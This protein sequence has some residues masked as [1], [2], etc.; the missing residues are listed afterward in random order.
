VRS[1]DKYM[2][3]KGSV[4]LPRQ[5]QFGLRLWQLIADVITYRG[6]V[7]GINRF[8][9]SKIRDRAT[10]PSHFLLIRAAICDSLPKIP[11]CYVIT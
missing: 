4:L 2:V 10:H 7:L 8:G 11:G 6:E 5:L 3:W 9:L 1:L